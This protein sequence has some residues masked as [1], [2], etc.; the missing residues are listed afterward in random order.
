MLGDWRQQEGSERELT[1]S[2]L[3]RLSCMQ[4][5]VWRSVC[6]Q[7][8]PVLGDQINATGQRGSKQQALSCK[9]PGR[10][11][12]LETRLTGTQL[13]WCLAV[14]KLMI[15]FFLYQN[16]LFSLHQFRVQGLGF[17]VQGIIFEVQ[18]SCSLQKWR[19]LGLR[20]QGLGFRVEWV[21][22]KV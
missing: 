17:R 22:R 11:N 20:V 8:M 6:P 10:R 5:T 15:I 18:G 12:N 2:L 21:Q 3:D 1:D 4:L 14:F 9:G 19:A 13:E 7:Q 16:S